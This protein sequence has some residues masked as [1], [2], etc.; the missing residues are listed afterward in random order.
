MESVLSGMQRRWVRGGEARRLVWKGDGKLEILAKEGRRVRRNG[1]GNNHVDDDGDEDE[2]EEEEL[3]ANEMSGNSQGALGSLLPPAS[4]TSRAA[5]TVAADR[6]R[7]D[8]SDAGLLKYQFPFEKA[9]EGE[10]QRGLG[11]DWE[12]IDLEGGN[13]IGIKT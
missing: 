5:S 2:R 9:D 10:E 1:N 6:D 11:I 3:T 8:L 13:N 7:G 4:M 12:D